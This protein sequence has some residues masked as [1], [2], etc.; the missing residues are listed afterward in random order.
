MD[1]KQLGQFKR[2]IK[3]CKRQGKD[4]TLLKEVIVRLAIPEKLPEKNRPHKL[5]GD[6]SEWR[7][8]HIAPDWIL[9]YRYEENALILFRTGSPT[10]IFEK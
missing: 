1:I 10:D 9:V 3:R 4:L 8:C 7:E 2:D 6:L 5:S